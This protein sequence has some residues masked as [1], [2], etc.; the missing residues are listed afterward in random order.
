MAPKR[1]H[2]PPSRFP[3][4]ERREPQKLQSSLGLLRDWRQASGATAIVF[5]VLLPFAVAWHVAYVVAFVASLIS[6]VTLAL[7]CHAILEQRLMM[8]AIFPELAQLPDLAT[9]RRRLVSPRSRRAL[10]NRLRYTA[11]PTQPPRRFDCCPLL[12]DRIAAIRPELLK[13]ADALEQSTA[14]DPA[15]VALL[16]ELLADGCSPLYN[17]NVP[18]DDLHAT[19]SRAS[20]GIAGGPRA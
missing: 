3:L 9:T 20:A 7:G 18:A 6:T 17:L 1:T 15:S 10:A 2:V 11:A 16:H 12:P 19:L 5:A 4:R 14:P 13:L 8:V